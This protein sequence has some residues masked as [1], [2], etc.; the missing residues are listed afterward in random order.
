MASGPAAG[1]DQR[2]ARIG[3]AAFA[4]ARRICGNSAVAADVVEQAFAS[5]GGEAEGAVG[6]GLLLRRVRALACGA[7]GPAQRGARAATGA[8]PPALS[9]LTAPQ[10]QVLELIALRGA[11]ASAAAGQLGLPEAT[12]IARLHDALQVAGSLLSAGCA[13]EPDDHPQAPRLALLG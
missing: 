4:L 11:S 2:Y 13:R 1:L 12:V 7:R 8:P 9:E 3:A 6:D 10:W 5:A